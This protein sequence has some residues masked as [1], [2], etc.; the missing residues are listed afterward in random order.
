MSDSAGEIMLPPK[1]KRGKHD[2]TENEENTDR[3][4]DLPDC[5]LL[6]ILS[7][8]ERQIRSWNLRFVHEMEGPLEAYSNPYIAFLRLLHCEDFCQICVYA[9]DSS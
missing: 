1:T 2:E 5:V 4:S 3:L 7:F 6:H 8:F 9:F